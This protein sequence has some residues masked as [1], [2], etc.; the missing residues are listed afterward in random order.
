MSIQSDIFLRRLLVPRSLA[1]MALPSSRY[2]SFL[3]LNSYL[4]LNPMWKHICVLALKR[5]NQASWTW[6]MNSGINCVVICKNELFRLFPQYMILLVKAT[7]ARPEFFSVFG[8][9]GYNYF[10]PSRQKKFVDHPIR[11]FIF[12]FWL[13]IYIL[14]RAGTTLPGD[15]MSW[16]F[17]DP[18]LCQCILASDTSIW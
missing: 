7:T 1:K 18:V 14:L 10:S 2:W 11:Q 12:H 5:T 4:V 8:D 6:W 15:P 16:G 17:M 3:T 13:V 9:G